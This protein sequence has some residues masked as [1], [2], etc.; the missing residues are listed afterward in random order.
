MDAREASEAG[1]AVC[2]ALNPNLLVQKRAKV[3]R[4][5]RACV[6]VCDRGGEHLCDQQSVSV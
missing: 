1:A 4:Q 6:R 2:V 5:V 3:L